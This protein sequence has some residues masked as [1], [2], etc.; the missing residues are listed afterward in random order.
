M[1]F[2]KASWK[3]IRIGILWKYLTPYCHCQKPLTRRAYRIALWAP[4]VTLGLLP[5]AV[6]LL[7]PA[8]GWG[9]FGVFFF[10]AAGGDLALDHALKKVPPAA[11]LL[12]HPSELG[13]LILSD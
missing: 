12:D 11:R 9:L 5:M 2:G 13:F 7:L 8:S 10:G 1:I 4:A 6:G 3:D